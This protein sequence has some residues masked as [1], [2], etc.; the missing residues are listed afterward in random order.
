MAAN[1]LN[2]LNDNLARVAGPAIG[3]VLVPSAGLAGIGVFDAASFAIA[4]ALI[5][6]IRTDAAPE[7]TRAEGDEAEAGRPAAAVLRGWV[8][9]LRLIKGP[10]AILV[11]F[12][13][14]RNGDAGGQYLERFARTVRRGRLE[15]RGFG[16]RPDPDLPRCRR[17]TGRGRGSLRI[18]MVAPGA[19]ARVESEH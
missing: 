2:A 1:G 5:S 18:P 11:L 3:G 6:L 7:A 17:D 14:E 9:G 4:A 10:R 13:V 19:G 8:E 16:F 12:V 15:S